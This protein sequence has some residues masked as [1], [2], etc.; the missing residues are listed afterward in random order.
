MT[1]ASNNTLEVKQLNYELN[2]H[3]TIVLADAL[4]ITIRNNQKCFVQIY[5]NICNPDNIR[6]SFPGSGTGNITCILSF[7]ISITIN[8]NSAA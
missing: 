5:I 1:I 2:L 8:L 3:L 7:T 4:K 6:S